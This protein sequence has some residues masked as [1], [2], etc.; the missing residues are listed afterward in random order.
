M[1]IDTT[2][3][4]VIAPQVAESPDWFTREEAAA[5]LHRN[6]RTLEQWAYKGVGPRY[7]RVG[8]RGRAI[9]RRE[10][11]DAFVAAHLVETDIGGDAA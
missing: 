6:P 10:D 1:P 8:K 4:P 9:Y 5:L 2:R 7:S 3:K 11:L